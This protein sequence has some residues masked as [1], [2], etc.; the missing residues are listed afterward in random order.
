[1][2]ISDCQFTAQVIQATRG[3][4]WS[5]ALKN[6]A[7]S[8][9]CCAM[10]RWTGEMSAAIES[11]AGALPEP[12]LIWLKAR[13]RARAQP[14]KPVPLPIGVAQWLGAAG[15]GVLFAGVSERIWEWPS[16]VFSLAS[17]APGFSETLASWLGQPQ[18]MLWLLPAGILL[19]LTLG[20]AAS[21]V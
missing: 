9:E 14:P 2:K 13:L 10:A 3:G 4:N 18:A 16:R 19:L 8:C 7:A 20:L 11:R 21:E 5:E 17:L 1:M 12:E 6:H 15:L